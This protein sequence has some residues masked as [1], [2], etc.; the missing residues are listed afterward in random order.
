MDKHERVFI[1]SQNAL[2]PLLSFCLITRIAAET[3]FI[4]SIH[5]VLLCSERNEIKDVFAEHKIHS[6]FSNSAENI[7][8]ERKSLVS[9][10]ALRSFIY[11]IISQTREYSLLTKQISRDTRNFYRLQRGVACTLG[12]A[13][14]IVT[15][16]AHLTPISKHIRSTIRDINVTRANNVRQIVSTYFFYRTI[17]N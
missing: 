7:S 16:R 4:N 1:V 12:S 8:F 10:C 5:D 13:F 3:A 2:R 11:E 9:T 14:R 15:S 17:T 6:S